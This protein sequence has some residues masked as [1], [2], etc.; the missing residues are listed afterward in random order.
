MS[1]IN[2]L[3][4]NN[5]IKYLNI[6]IDNPNLETIYYLIENGQKYSYSELLED[7][8]GYIYVPYDIFKQGEL[9]ILDIIENI[10]ANLTK[11]EIAKYLYI[12]IGKN[13]GYDINIIP[14]KNETFNLL[15][16]NQINN[17]W[18]CL[19]NNKGTNK[20]FT[21]LYKYLCKIMN[22]DCKIISNNI[23]YLKNVLTIDNRK[24]IVD[25]TSDI[26][27]I[28]AGFKTKNFTGYNDDLTLDKKIGYIKDNY[29]EN[30]IEL[31]L[32]NLNYDNDL[33]FNNILSITQDIIKVENIKPIELGIIYDQIF[34]K[35]CPD[36]NISINN[37]YINHNNKKE[38]FILI[39]HDDKYYSYNYTKNSFVEISYDEIEKNIESKKIGIYLNENISF[40]NPKKVIL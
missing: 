15:N 23:G 3:K 1:D 40:L 16:I 34:T 18:G 12:T 32:K 38:H 36:Q 2:K 17:I 6:D 5:N 24:I 9:F 39:H 29:N 37:L 20:S 13:I 26:P 8:K 31:S 33:V 19:C 14:E 10:P 27:F 4:E 22:I 11:L 35:Y 7:K 28:Q 25:I 21:K 30:I